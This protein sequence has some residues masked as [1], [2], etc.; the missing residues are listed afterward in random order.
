M[1]VVPPPTTRRFNWRTL[2]FTVV[3][4]VAALMYGS[5]IRLV[6]APWVLTG[7]QTGLQ[8]PELDRWHDALMGISTGVL[9]GGSL[10]ALLWRPREKPLLLQYLALATVAGVLL[11]APFVGPFMFIIAVPII[12]V[13]IAY[14]APR[15]L[16][17]FAREEHAS[18]LLLALSVV[19]ALLLAPI[20]WHSF[21][22]QVQG[23]GG[24]SATANEWIADVE[25]TLLLLL[26]GFMTSTKRPGWRPLGILT[27]VTFLY[28]G[29]A[30][31]AVPHHAGSWGIIGGVLAL[32]GGVGYI[33]ATLFEARTTSMHAHRAVD[34]G[35]APR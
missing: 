12:L 17:N 25:H 30:A 13:I 35:L 29:I 27:G 2:V 9:T 10:L 6:I 18:R 31:L 21:I 7:P 26:A 3:T 28:L 23:V 11:N 4:V 20:I 8:N 19:A 1:T 34:T 24:Q 5:T 32:L 15:A 16:L 22:W 14:P 33:A